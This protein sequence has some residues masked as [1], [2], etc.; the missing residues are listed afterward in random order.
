M[1]T[2]VDK[3]LLRQ[4]VQDFCGEFPVFRLKEV[5]MSMLSSSAAGFRDDGQT[6]SGKHYLD[7]KINED[8]ICWKHQFLFLSIIFLALC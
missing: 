2:E 4:V 7:K 6:R 1:T 3:A 8:E 5:D